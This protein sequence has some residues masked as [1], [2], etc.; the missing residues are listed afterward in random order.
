MSFW[1]LANLLMARILIFAES[2]TKKRSS[3]SPNMLDKIEK[4][5]LKFCCSGKVLVKVVL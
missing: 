2:E 3:F 1:L 5:G 4:Q